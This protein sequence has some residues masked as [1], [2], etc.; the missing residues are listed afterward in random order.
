MMP[1]SS[2]NRKAMASL[3]PLISWNKRNVQV[4]PNKP[5]PPFV[6]LANIKKK[7]ARL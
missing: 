2:T 1:R 7:K 5:A 3:T 4:F 6:L